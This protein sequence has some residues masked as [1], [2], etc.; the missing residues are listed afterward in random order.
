MHSHLGIIPS[1]SI[2]EHA[3]DEIKSMSEEQFGYSVFEELVE[4]DGIEFTLTPITSTELFSWASLWARS[5]LS[6]KSNTVTQLLM[7]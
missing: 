7:K 2:L 4:E 5:G 1:I 3:L 6:T